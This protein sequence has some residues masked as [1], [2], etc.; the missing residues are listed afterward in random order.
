[1][2][3]T[4]FLGTL[5][6]ILLLIFALFTIKSGKNSKL[7]NLLLASFLLS[8]FFCL[9]GFIIPDL[10]QFININLSQMVD[11]GFPFWF[12]FGPTLFL[13]TKSITNNNY[14]FSIANFLHG[15]PFVLSFF[16][17]ISA[18]DTES[19]FFIFCFNI[20][21]FIYLILCIKVLKKYRVKI[22]TYYSSIDKINFSWLQYIIGAFMIM[23]LIDFI[24][25]YL[26]LIDFNTPIIHET[27]SLTSISIN[28]IFIVIIFYKA[29]Q[30]PQ[31]LN[32]YSEDETEKYKGSQLTIE[33]KRIQLEHL[34]KYFVKEKPYLNPGL[35]IS[36]V[37]KTIDI[38]V[39]N[40][41]QIINEL[42][43]KNFY[44]FT[45]SFRINLAK[46]MLIDQENEHLTVLEILYNSGFN[47]KSAFN[48]AFK[49]HTSLTPTE[50]RNRN[51][52][53]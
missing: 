46:D 32:N 19:P 43:K 13:F 16:F 37:A 47:S 9:F 49:K 3:L 8:N 12:L 23:W 50:F 48:A 18:I 2:T 15:I 30:E 35:T 26:S 29:L 21:V 39:R 5:A 28:L 17:L 25:Y 14:K 10:N 33:T 1:M 20:Q 45:N 36:D 7:S 11:F 27:L 31:F 44:D 53:H 52:T 41:S 34:E 40:I 42:L 51:T 4:T 6:A 24:N 22:K 38:P